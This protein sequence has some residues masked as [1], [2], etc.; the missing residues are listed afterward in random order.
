[1]SQTQFQDIDQ[2]Y[3]LK[4]REQENK[5]NGQSDW[6]IITTRISYYLCSQKGK[7]MFKVSQ[8]GKL[9]SRDSRDLE[10]LVSSAICWM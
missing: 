3:Q 6:K 2:S 5:E 9:E 8:L 4:I 1:M 10:G 7:G